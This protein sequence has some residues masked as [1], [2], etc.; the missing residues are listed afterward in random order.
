M[1]AIKREKN[2]FPMVVSSCAFLDGVLR[3]RVPFPFL[4]FLFFFRR[5][6]EV[7]SPN[8]SS[9]CMAWSMEC[10]SNAGLASCASDTPVLLVNNLYKIENHSNKDTIDNLLLLVAL[11]LL[12]AS[13]SL[14]L[15]ANVH[16]CKACT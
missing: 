3:F 1:G 11:T 2:E 13:N 9:D 4:S 12:S 10:Y 14:R 16:R 6:V 8:D 7:S 15:L 5:G